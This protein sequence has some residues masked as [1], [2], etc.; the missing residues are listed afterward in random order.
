MKKVLLV[1]AAVFLLTGCFVSISVPA[2]AMSENLRDQP[3]SIEKAME[4]CWGQENPGC[5]EGFFHYEN[6]DKTMIVYYND[7]QS[8]KCQTFE[9]KEAGV[10]VAIT[11]DGRGSRPPGNILVFQSPATLVHGCKIIFS[12]R[13]GFQIQ[14]GPE[15]FLLPNFSDLK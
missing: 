7:D 5:Q 13:T 3:I 2:P 9:L 15:N 10:L 14:G 11:D 4:W 8:T 12:T 1:L 6:E